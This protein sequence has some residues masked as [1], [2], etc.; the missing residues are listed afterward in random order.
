[1]NKNKAQVKRKRHSL[2]YILFTWV[3][4]VLSLFLLVPTGA[5]IGAETVSFR[6]CNVNNND[7]VID[8]C[9]KQSLNMGDLVI[10]LLFV[11]SLCVVVCL[12]THAW[13]ISRGT[14]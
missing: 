4:A 3:A 14:V 8:A 12:F 7:L 6:S 10:L 2:S 11:G 13:R 5:A 9:G 1:M